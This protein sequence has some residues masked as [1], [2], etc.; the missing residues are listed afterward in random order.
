MDTSDAA[1]AFT[2]M[3]HAIDARDWNGVRAAFADRIDIDYSSLFGVPA[4]TVGADDHV[5]AWR[6]FGEVFDA[7]QHVTGPIVLTSGSDEVTAHTH[8]RAYHRM[9]GITGGETWMVAGHYTVRL[10]SNRDAWTIAGITLTVFYQDG[11]LT[12]PEL[13]RARAASRAHAGKAMTA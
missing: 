3:L 8:V 13:A 1:T 10:V 9:T 4:A 5:A 12:I 2:L 11:N 7:T 6:A